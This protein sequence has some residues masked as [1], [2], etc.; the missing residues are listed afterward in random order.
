[1]PKWLER[2]MLFGRRLIER[3]LG[4]FLNPLYPTVVAILLL[5]T[6]GMGS[7]WSPEIRSAFPFAASPTGPLSPLACVFWASAFVSGILYF[8]HQF[9]NGLLQ[10]RV[11]KKLLDRTKELEEVLRSMPPVNFLED[12]AELTSNADTIIEVCTREDTDADTIHRGVRQILGSVS[13]LAQAF[14]GDHRDCLYSA[15]IML[16]EPVDG[17]ESG[18]MEQLQS[19]LIFADDAVAIE[20][21]AGVLRLMPALSTTSADAT[22]GPDLSLNEL[23]LPVPNSI[24]V[25]GRFIVLPGAPLAVATGQPDLCID[26]K[27]L[28]VWCEQHGDFTAAVRNRIRHHFTE[29]QG[30]NVRSFISIPLFGRMDDG[31]PDTASGAIAVLNIHSDRVGMLKSSGTR[32]GQFVPILRPFLISLTKLIEA[33]VDTDVEAEGDVQAKDDASPKCDPQPEGDIE[34]R[35][36]AEA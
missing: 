28:H 2:C 26:T 18:N 31:G 3:N 5:I 32:G 10:E 25:D 15:N 36:D 13:T 19:S 30:R 12:F 29:G 7:I 27:D 33:L 8:L 14:D 6:G 21:L 34:P 35:G 16:Y 1:M 23:T 22:A 4:L 9:A 17:L 20:R 24:T 11:Q